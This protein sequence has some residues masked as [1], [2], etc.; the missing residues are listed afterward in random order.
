[1]PCSTKGISVYEPGID[2]GAPIPRIR[3]CPG[4]R[5]PH[6]RSELRF[7]PALDELAGQQIAEQVPHRVAAGHV[8]A[9]L[10]GRSKCGEKAAIE[11][12]MRH[13]RAMARRQSLEALNCDL[14]IPPRLEE[15]NPRIP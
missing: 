12:R 13:C 8:S 15:T 1:M 7:A 6:R 9:A 2:A 4:P 3:E 11:K 10:P 5:P 14:E